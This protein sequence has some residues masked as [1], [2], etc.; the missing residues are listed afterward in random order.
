MVL[1]RVGEHIYE[2]FTMK[3]LW[4]GAQTTF[5]EKVGMTLEL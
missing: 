5:E 2:W 4:T 1:N 3:F